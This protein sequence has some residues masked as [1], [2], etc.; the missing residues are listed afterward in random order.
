MAKVIVRVKGGLGN[1]LF[2]Y[3]A[4]RRLALVNDAELVVDDV[5]GFCRDKIYG[6]KYALDKFNIKARKATPAERME[7][8]E[9]GRRAMA[10]YFSKARPFNKRRY[11]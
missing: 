3:A 4:A 7:P 2:C 10:K 9:R 1:Q 5:T 11:V 6:C 8:F